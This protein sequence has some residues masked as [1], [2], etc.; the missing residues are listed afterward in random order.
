MSF[1][2]SDELKAL[3]AER[4]RLMKRAIDEAR[5]G[6]G[7]SLGDTIREI[8]ALDARVFAAFAIITGSRS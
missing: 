1:L 4:T 7:Y 8:E 3:S 5:R 6:A 2:T